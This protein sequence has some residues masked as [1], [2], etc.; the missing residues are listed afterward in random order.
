MCHINSFWLI[1]LF[2]FFFKF[3]IYFTSILFTGEIKNNILCL[4]SYVTALI[5]HNPGRKNRLIQTGKAFAN[6]GVIYHTGSRGAVRSGTIYLLDFFIRVFNDDYVV[7]TQESHI[8]LVLEEQYD[9]GLY[10]YLFS[11]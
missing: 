3:E 9:Q 4:E 8:R 11:S 6:V 7:L 5:R 2:L 1:W 10:I